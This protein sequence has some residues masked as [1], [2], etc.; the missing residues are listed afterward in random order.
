MDWKWADI[1]DF[2]V[3]NA[4]SLLASLGS[5]AVV[6]GLFVKKSTDK[7]KHKQEVMLREFD[8]T[9]RDRE[10]IA[11]DLAQERADKA[12]LINEQIKDLEHENEIADQR[13]KS[14]EIRLEEKKTDLD[15][16]RMYIRDLEA[17][18]RA[19]RK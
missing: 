6:G 9:L 15:E 11:A 8:A 12:R 14:C 17:Q 18:L 10:K 3:R 13:W 7:Q 19:S 1:W 4:D 2:V 16:A 5:L